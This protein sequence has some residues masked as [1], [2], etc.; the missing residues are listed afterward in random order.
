[1]RSIVA[2]FA[3][4]AAGATRLTFSVDS[5]TSPST[6]LP[7]SSAVPEPATWAL[8]IVGFGLVG[9]ASR[10][11]GGQQLRHAKAI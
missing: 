1:M 2:R 8:M 7:P 5:I 6:I 10:R 9:A 3:F 4:G 11:R